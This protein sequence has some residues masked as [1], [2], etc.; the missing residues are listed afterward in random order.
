MAWVDL[1]MLFG[2]EDGVDRYT[3]GNN[4]KKGCFQREN[5]DSLVS[6]GTLSWTYIELLSHCMCCNIDIMDII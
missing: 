5:D 3:T 4:K 2:F 1:F 6:L